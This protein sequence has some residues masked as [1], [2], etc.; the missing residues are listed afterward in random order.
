MKLTGKVAVVTGG[1]Q[2]I[3][4]A[5]ALA[6]AEEGADVVIYDMNLEST[7]RVT[8][9]IKNLGRLA[10][11]IKC[12]VSN[13]QAVNQATQKAL[14]NFKRIDILVNNAGIGEPALAEDTTEASWDRT[15]D[16]NLKG[17]F[18]CSQAVGRQMIKQKYGKIINIASLQ[19]HVATPLH[20][21]YAVSKAGVLG[22]TRVL[23]VEWALYNI[24]V[25]AVSPGS[26]VTAQRGQAEKK[27]PELLTE[28][29]VAKIPQGHPNK[30][31]DIA[32]AVLFLASPESDNIT[33]QSI[34]VDGGVV[35]HHSV[36][37]YSIPK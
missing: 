10:L 15:I 14:D 16:I 25:N 12:D 30:P 6:F 9:E 27:F 4:R 32:N 18:L 8:D 3:G 33:G 37:L 1:G 20:I 31:E 11:A 22:L 28:N 29:P 23:A 35:A 19:A 26:T 13:S 21:A 5:C 36:A 7:N 24:S 34:I 17:Q 2:G